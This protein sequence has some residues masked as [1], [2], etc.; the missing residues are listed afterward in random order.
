MSWEEC[1][2]RCRICE[3][4]VRRRYY[5]DYDMPSS[6]TCLCAECKEKGFR[7][8]ELSLIYNKNKIT[9]EEVYKEYDIFIKTIEN[10]TNLGMNK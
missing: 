5:D 2:Q 1:Y 10:K 3:K 6:R 4:E 8:E 7:I 9:L